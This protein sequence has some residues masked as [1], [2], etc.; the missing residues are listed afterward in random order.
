MASITAPT[1]DP[2][3]TA[4]ALADQTIL[5][6]QQILQRQ[7]AAATATERGLTD[8]G[9]AL[10]AFQSSLSALTSSDKTLFAQS[11]TFSD[12]DA[13]SATAGARAAAGSYSFFVARVATA[14]QVSLS[15]LSDDAAVTG[16]LKIDLGGANALSIDMSAADAD[17]NGILTTRELAAAINGDVKNTGLISA[18]IITT[19]GSAELVLSARNTG[20]NSAITLD[21]SGINGGSSLAAANADPARVRILSA[22]QDAEIRVG[23]E[24]GT[25]IIQASNTFTNIDGVKMTFTKAQAAGAAPLTLMVGPDTSATIANV[26]GFVDA[27]N[28]LKT[29]LSRLTASGDPSKGVTAGAFAQDSSIRALSERLVNVLRPSAGGDTLASYGILATKDGTLELR[30]DRLVRQLTVKPTGLDTLIGS[31]SAA[32]TSG[33]AGTLD[34]YIKT[35][36]NA[37]DGLIK[38]RKEAGATQQKGIEERLAYL[39]DQ[40]EA[41]YQ[42]YLRQFTDLQNL[43]SAMTSNLSMF[44]ALFGNDKD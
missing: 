13:A 6:R 25:P 29:V 37:T 24:S 35:W 22:A 43:Q 41:A 8:L 5:P 10:S 15:G 12:K 38:E 28:K 27:Y 19:G 36:T 31:A 21:T 16:V 30:A 44:D 9:S 20:A 7:S 34:S 23:S 33:I 2:V 32:S 14:S 39:E 42:R 3:S 11:A 17:K 4:T 26:Q 1:Y 18:S 40:H